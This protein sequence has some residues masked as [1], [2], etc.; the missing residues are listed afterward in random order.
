MRRVIEGRIYDT[1]T[2]DCLHSY[3]APHY[4][5]DFHWFKEAL[6][7]TRKGAYFVSGEGNALSRWAEPCADGRG[8]GEGIRPLSP[9]EAL[10]WM[11]DHGADA[12]DIAEA[13]SDKVEEA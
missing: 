3:E 4:C 6:Y 10:A 12:D 13:F 11:E 2:A 7:R 1:E 8:P 9:D 5:S